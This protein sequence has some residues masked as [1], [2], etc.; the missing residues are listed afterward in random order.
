MHSKT[1][2]DIFIHKQVLP[3]YVVYKLSL[4]GSICACRILWQMLNSGK[5]DIVW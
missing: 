5:L 1:K 4:V 3:S 2:Q